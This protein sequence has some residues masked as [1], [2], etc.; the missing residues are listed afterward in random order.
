MLIEAR[1]WPVAPRPFPEEAMGSW[2]GRVAACYRVSVE[3]L[4][5]DGAIEVDTSGHL[6]WLLPAS[7]PSD[8]LRRLARLARLD[9][10]R[11]SAIEAPPS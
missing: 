2:I 3:Q 6:G 11:L 1:A 5:E 8:Q 10:D 7:L 9:P 4:C